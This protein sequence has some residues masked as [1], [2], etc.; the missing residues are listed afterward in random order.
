[1]LAA[2]VCIALLESAPANADIRRSR[3]NLAHITPGIASDVEVCI[4]CHTPQTAAQVEDMP[5]PRWTR[6]LENRGAFSLYEDIDRGALSAAGARGSHSLV[7]L[8]C[9]DGSQAP[10]LRPIGVNAEHPWGIPYRGPLATDGAQVALASDASDAPVTRMEA[11]ALADEFKEAASSVIGGRRVWWVPRQAGAALRT[12]QDIPLYS[13]G[14]AGAEVP[15]IEC[16]SC[17]DP[18]SDRSLFLRVADDRSSLCYACH[19]K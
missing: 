11:F 7:C 19:V 15:F 5:A 12:R 1:M 2:L 9:H 14:S 8:S 18:H 17:H 10:N 6:S 3:H 13:R 4:F 16:A